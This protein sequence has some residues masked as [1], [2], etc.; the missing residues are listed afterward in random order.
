[1]QEQKPGWKTSEFWLSMGAIIIGG[2]M[3]S[4]VLDSLGGDHWA[5]K[6]VGIVASILG[7]LGYTATRGFVKVSKN[8]ADALTAIAKNGAASKDPT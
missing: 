5:V 8:K 2:V 1:M 4:G 7:A 3:A 6:V